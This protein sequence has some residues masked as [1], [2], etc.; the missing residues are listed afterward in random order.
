S[1]PIVSGD[2]VFVTCYSGYGMKPPTNDDDPAKLV[3]HLLAFDRASGRQLWEVK[4]PSAEKEDPFAGFIMQHGYAS[5]TPTT[6]GKRVYA[7]FGKSGLF[8]FDMDGNELWRR[9]L[10][11]KSDPARWGGGASPVL[12]KNLVLV[13]AGVVG[14]QLVAVDSASGEIAWSIEDGAF[15]NCWTTPAIINTENGEQAIFAVPGKMIAVEP[16][17]GTKVWEAATQ[18]DDATCGSI[19]HREGIAYLMGS[20][21]GHGLAV[22]CDGKGDVSDS[23]TIWSKQIRSGIC[24]PVIVGESL[25]WTTGGMFMAARVED[26][27][28]AYR[29]RLPRKGKASGGFMAADYSSPVAQG[30]RILLFTR[31]GESYVIEAGDE[32]EVVGQNPGFPDDETPFNATP[33][34]SDGEIFVRSDK[35]LYCIAED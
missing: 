8:A 12:Y 1:S 13:N 6:D 16:L 11:T 17:T 32:F 21:E 35:R 24:T 23:S 5:S 9:S 2:K 7:F 27:E 19:V 4:V 34:I 18:I 25:Y 15:T 10:G 28:Y 26:G 31:F 33:A 30:N 3:R 22:R 14:N 20:R 29:V